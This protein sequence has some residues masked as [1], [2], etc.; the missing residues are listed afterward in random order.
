MSSNDRQHFESYREQTNVK[1]VILEKYIWAYFSILKRWHPNLVYIDGFAGKGTYEGADGVEVLG[2]PLRAL[3]TIASSA[4]LSKAVSTVFIEKDAFLAEQLESSIQTFLSE[5]SN[6]RPPI[7]HCGEFSDS[8]TN[9]INNLE[10]GGKEL[11]PTFMFVDPCGVSGTS[12]DVIQRFLN[13][14]SCETF[15]FFNIAAV[16]R[17]VGL[18]NAMAG[19]LPE[20]LGSEE[21]AKELAKI[22]AHCHSPY[23][24]ETAILNFY[25]KTLRTETKAK[26]VTP[27]RIESEDKRVTSHYLFHATTHPTGFRIMKDVMWSAGIRAE[28]VGGLEFAQASLNT[29]QPLFDIQMSRIK[30]S[31]LEVLSAHGPVKAQLFYAQLVEHPDNMI[32]TNGYR[33]ALLALEDEGKIH[34]LAKN[35]SGDLASNRRKGTLAKDYYIRAAELPPN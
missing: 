4:D 22:V 12:F 11:A 26:Y 8:L 5:H 3:K 25:I 20:L 27:F 23:E 2:S 28:G 29:V 6:I 1:H 14:P 34:V 13:I 21:R 18:G 10:I 24:R 7:I 31:V 17:I 16:R 19:T 33:Q 15:I 9:L 30:E 32:S 35:G